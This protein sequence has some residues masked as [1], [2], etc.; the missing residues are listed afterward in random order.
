M[1]VNQVAK[2]LLANARTQQSITIFSLV[3]SQEFP[4]D[5]VQESGVLGLGAGGRLMALQGRDLDELRTGN[6]D[7]SVSGGVGGIEQVEQRGKDQ[8]LRFDRSQRCRS[9][10]TEVRG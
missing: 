9:I 6:S 8:G 3:P 2:F 10:A 5:A 7:G 1:A 4:D